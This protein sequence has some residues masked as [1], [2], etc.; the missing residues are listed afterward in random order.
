MS[1]KDFHYTYCDEIMMHRV[2]EDNCFQRECMKMVT[3]LLDQMFKGVT[4]VWTC[5][6]S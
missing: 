3:N 2:Q 4:S 6:K 5:Y 1:L